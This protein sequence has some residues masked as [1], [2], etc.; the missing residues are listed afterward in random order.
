MELP[1]AAHT[2]TAPTPAAGWPRYFVIADGD[3]HAAVLG[4]GRTAAKTALRCPLGK[5]LLHHRK[6]FDAV[7]S[8]TLDL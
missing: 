3:P 8:H 7:G 5:H 2:E 4:V 6:P 1:V